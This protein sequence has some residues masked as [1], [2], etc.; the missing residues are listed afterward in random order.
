MNE[1]K[2]VVFVCIENAC[3]SQMA[4]GFAK[5][6]GYDIIEAYSS[7]SRPSGKI[8]EK[9]ITAM[10]DTGYDLRTH[11]S[12]SIN[13]IP[14]IEYDWVVTMGCGDTC[15]AVRGK[16]HESWDIPDPKKMD[17]ARFNQVRDTIRQKVMRLIN[18]IQN[19]P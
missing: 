12:K 13:T 14:D 17:Q 9:A 5:M 11:A 4:E 7:G 15:P 3:R 8:N 1:K 18:T 16:Q 19:A 2:T 6:L 10:E